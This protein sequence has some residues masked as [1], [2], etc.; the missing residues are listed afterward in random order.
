MARDIRR[1]AW[2]RRRLFACAQ[3]L[4]KRA[5][6]EFEA[7]LRRYGLA[8]V[9]AKAKRTRRSQARNIRWAILTSHGRAPRLRAVLKQSGKALRRAILGA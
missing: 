3:M 6:S 9:A 7:L 1:L 2:I 4:D 8:E 5:D